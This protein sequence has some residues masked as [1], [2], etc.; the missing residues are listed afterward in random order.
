MSHKAIL[1]VTDIAVSTDYGK[2][3]M[4]LTP[5]GEILYTVEVP[6]EGYEEVDGKKVFNIK[7]IRHLI[8]SSTIALVF[9]ADEEDF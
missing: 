4:G 9:D 2:K 1:Q 5:V 3:K 8:K 7:G 6:E